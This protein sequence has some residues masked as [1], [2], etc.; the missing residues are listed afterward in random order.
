M[1]NEA[2]LKIN[3]SSIERTTVAVDALYASLVKLGKGSENVEGKNNKLAASQKRKQAALLSA[4][5]ASEKAIELLKLEQKGLDKTS[6]EYAKLKANIIAKEVAAKKG[7]STSSKE[8]KVLKSNIRAKEKATTETKRLSSAQRRLQLQTQLTSKGMGKYTDKLDDAAKQAVLIDGALG[9]VS[10]RMTALSSIM[11]SGALGFAAIGLSAA[12]AFREIYKGVGIAAD[13]EVAMKAFDAQIV[14]TGGAAGFTAGELDNLSRSLAL[15]TLDSTEDM[16]KLVGVMLTFKSVTGDAFTSSIGLAQDLG[17][18]M[19]QDPVTAART[20]GKVLQ[21]PLKNYKQ[22]SRAGIDFSKVEAENIKLL[23]QRGKIDEAQA[24]IIEKLEGKFGGLARA[25]AE[26]LRG[27]IDTFNQKWEETSEIV[28]ERLLPAMRRLTQIGSSALDGVADALAGDVGEIVSEWESGFDTMKKS[29]EELEAELKRVRSE[30]DLLGKADGLDK[31]YDGFIAM[32]TVA[33]GIV[34]AT[35]VDKLEAWNAVE[36]K[37]F[38]AIQARRKAQEIPPKNEALDKYKEDAELRLSTEERLTEAFLLYSNTRSEGYRNEKAQV[39]AL[40]LSKKLGIEGDEKE[41]ALVAEHIKSLSDLVEQRVRHNSVIQAEKSIDNRIRSM[42][43]ELDLHKLM[44][45]SIREGSEEYIKTSVAIDAR[46]QALRAGF[47]VGSQEYDQIVK[48]SEALA[49]MQIELQRINDLRTAGVG[50]AS[51][52]RLFDSD[53]LIASRQDM[54]EKLEALRRLDLED[55]EVYQQREQAIRQ[56]Y[57]DAKTEALGIS[58]TVDKDGI[59]TMNTELEALEIE[60]QEKLSELAFAWNEGMITNDILYLERRNEV[61]LEYDE[62]LNNARLAAFNKTADGIA[63][64]RAA[65]VANNVSSIAKN[66]DAASGG[67]KKLA[68]ISKAAAI[69]SASTS[70]VKQLSAAASVE[71]YYA[72]FAAYAEAAATGASI[73]NM[74]SNLKE[75]SFANGGV[76]IKGRGT[77][78]S[79]SIKANIA[80][81]ESVITATATTRHKDTL[82]RMNAG[83]AINGS[84]ESTI[85]APMSITIMGD[86]SEKTVELIDE[87]L[88]KFE[89]RVQQI[90]QGVSIQTIQEEQGVGGL[91]NE[92]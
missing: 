88:Q 42:Q 10:S 24:I 39:E 77:G 13:T 34:D 26:T 74:A 54:Y 59:E 45:D 90:S 20:L 91:F 47:E 18:A 62:K 51:G 52:G 36:Q 40:R 75:P 15:N 3:S 92:I 89:T 58:F 83:L 11:K 70:L 9:G 84:K 80:N 21:N 76:D 8:F 2:E 86:A 78:R 37:L 29:P 5:I 56:E 44:N 17:K 49:D 79:D 85:T 12:L 33:D 38:N 55:I 66:L 64:I 63:L 22:L 57:A 28:G 4:N 48:S 32:T 53:S 41:I 82:R 72:K 6:Q 50:L 43:K 73:I 27:D 65:E 35:L 81:G 60:K 69:F 19:Q 68:K 14:A 71:P 31:L 61:N 67:S 25:Q 46:N 1:A 87:K 23:Q 16:R 7:I 30:L